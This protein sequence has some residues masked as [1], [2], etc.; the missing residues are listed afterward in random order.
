MANTKPANPQV[1]V[2]GFGRFLSI[3][4]NPS[5]E[6]ARRLPSSITTAS[7][8]TALLFVPR[9]AIPAK[10]AEVLDL[11]T[12]LIAIHAPDIVV[13]IGLAHDRTYFAVEKG[14]KK[15]GYN[16]VPDET[17][18]VFTR[19]ENKTAF[20]KEAARLD[21]TLDLA[22]ATAAW[23]EE[24]QG[25]KL[26]PQST[27]PRTQPGKANEKPKEKD[28]GK[29]KLRAAAETSAKGAV[30]GTQVDVRCSDDVGNYVCGLQYYASLL[31]MQ[32]QTGKR[33]TV[34]LHVPYLRTLDDIEVGVRVTE[35][36]IRALV[37]V[38][39]QRK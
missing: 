35:A 19:G 18:R 28:K 17:R 37:E 3:D 14:A 32:K 21:S 10:Y 12:E 16:D 33:D 22:A 8:T 1:L 15:E 27:A 29:Q 2:T 38:W 25:M 20:G 23:Q 39:A 5:H 7:N 9:K 26:K 31:A 6:I 4:V 13:H 11:T 36:L 34:F 24:V 30:N